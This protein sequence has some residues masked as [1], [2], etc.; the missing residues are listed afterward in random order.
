MKEVLKKLLLGTLP[1]L[2]GLSLIGCGS[3]SNVPEYKGMSVK[4]SSLAL[5]NQETSRKD[6]SSE[7]SISTPNDSIENDISTVVPI[8]TTN[9][10]ETV[11]YYVEKSE[12]FIVDINFSNPGN[13]QISTF[14]FNNKKY[15]S[16]SFEEGSTNED[17]LLAVTASTKPCY[18]TYTISDIK[19][20]DGEYSKEV[21]MSGDASIIVGVRYDVEPTATVTS[22]TIGTNYLTL[23]LKVIDEQKLIG[24]NPLYIYLSD[25]VN[26]ID[27]Q[28]LVV[29]DNTVTFLSLN[30]GTTYEYGVSAQ[31][32]LADG[33]NLQNHWILVNQFSTLKAFSLSSISSGKTSV[34]FNVDI[35][36][37]SGSITSIK[38]LDKDTKEVVQTSTITVDGFEDLLSNHNYIIEINFKY[39]DKSI[40]CTDTDTY[41]VKTLAKTTPQIEYSPITF[42]ETSISFIHYI[43]DEDSICTIDKVELYKGDVLEQTISSL[44]RKGTFSNLLSNT[45]YTLKSTYSYDLNDGGGKKSA[46]IS[47]VVKTTACT[48]PTI[49]FSSK[50]SDETSITFN[51]Y[52]RDPSSIC[53]F[54]KIELLKGTEVVSTASSIN[55]KKFT[56]L[57]SDTDYTIRITYSFNMND[58]TETRV[59]YASTSIRTKAKTAPEVTITNVSSTKTSVTYDYTKVDPSSIASIDKVELYLGDTLKDSYTGS[60]AN[61]FTNLLSNTEYTLKVLYSYDLN[62][63]TGIKS[64][65][66]T[67]IFTTKALTAP[68]I[69]IDIDTIS[70]TS[71]TGNVVVTDIDNKYTCDSVTLSATG[72]DDIV[73]DDLSRFEFTN[74]SYYTSYTLTVK[75][76]YDLNDGKGTNSS[77]F[78]VEYK[79]NPHISVT[80]TTSL[81]SQGVS[82]GDT[83]TINVNIVNPNNATPSSAVVNGKEIEVAS[84]STTEVVT[85]QILDEGQFDGGYTKFTVETINFTL[86]SVSYAYTPVNEYNYTTIFIKGP[87]YVVSIEYTVLTNISYEPVE[88]AFPSDVLYYYV[89]IFNKTGYTV[90]SLWIGGTEYSGA[91]LIRVDDSHYAVKVTNTSKGWITSYIN[92]VKYHYGNSIKYLNFSYIYT[93]EIFRLSYDEIKY[94]N[95]SNLKELNQGY[96]YKL[97]FD[98]DLGN[99]NWVGGAFYGVLD[100]NGHTINNLRN[101]LTYVD[102]SNVKMGL[103]TSA[104]GIISN[105]TIDNVY[106][107]V[108]VTSVNKQS[109]EIFAGALVSYV[110][111]DLKLNN[112]SLTN[113]NGSSYIKT[114][115][116]AGYSGGLIGFAN[117]SAHI[118]MNNCHTSVALS[119]ISRETYACSGGLI[120][121]SSGTYVTLNNCYSEGEVISTAKANDSDSYSGG[122]IGYCTN[123]LIV[124]NSYNAAKV[125]SNT[126]SGTKS[127]SYSGGLLGYGRM[128]KL[129][130]DGSYNTG[131]VTGNSSGDYVYVGGLTGYLNLICNLTLNN[132]YNSGT[133]TGSS[134]PYNYCGGIAGYI[135]TYG[136]SYSLSL[137]SVYNTGNVT[138]TATKNNSYAGGLIGYVTS[139]NTV[140][141]NK[142]YNTGNVTYT[143]IT[144]TE[145]TDIPGGGGLVGNMVADSLITYSYNKGAI[146]GY[147]SN[148]GLIGLLDPSY[149]ATIENSYNAGE[150]KTSVSGSQYEAYYPYAG[151]LI[152]TALTGSTININKCYNCGRVFI[153]SNYSLYAQ[154]LIGCLADGTTA[155]ITNSILGYSTGLTFIG[156]KN[157]TATLTITNSYVLPVGLLP[158]EGASHVSRDSLN[159]KSFYIDT[160]N[161]SEDIWDFT[162]LDVTSYLYPVLKA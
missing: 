81:N 88:Y 105:F 29:G 159:G 27:S 47:S 111:E 76:H 129:S 2:M 18:S 40:T 100:G 26:K 71:I 161:W 107:D 146:S 31:Y 150:I 9:T 114:T 149:T 68:T 83:I 113:S 117:N 92:S 77:S 131:S 67:T 50:T 134:S 135:T 141:I 93:D 24:K 53:T 110:T 23:E 147:Y 28:S 99:S 127:H 101:K 94:I 38:L 56:D 64:A 148:G 112:C 4:R 70:D 108:S 12:T 86:D 75:Y 63:G 144:S 39:V 49:T 153:S 14:T 25:G 142:C 10:D 21:K 138:S 80:S 124:N 91:S 85:I 32:D 1:L 116:S 5:Q 152:G 130:L 82:K 104:K 48:E 139:N 143:C 6:A 7:S 87:I 84:S 17:V 136:D 125:Q 97:N 61:N 102:N 151:G 42:D 90:D 11:K 137:N 73:S 109:Y 59:Q 162:S 145:N 140:K 154:N 115:A 122:L 74:L 33:N 46:S 62:D 45:E 103:F 119:S 13:Y 51:Y 15:S 44:T 156:V 16:S 98:C 66:S 96:Y 52:A 128:Y 36:G 118:I 72:E 54:E 132:A 37:R 58:L 8:S 34:S 133:I 57:L 41:E 155:T 30:I 95:S 78:S 158:E 160:L 69:S 126:A 65:S 89:T 106:I 19:Y 121:Y 120:A 55:Q 157:D 60:F 79:T 35:N 3:S 20:V 123:E 43:D 22:A